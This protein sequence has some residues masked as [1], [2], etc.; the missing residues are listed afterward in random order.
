MAVLLGVPPSAC[1]LPA[2]LTLK[3]LPAQRIAEEEPRME[4]GWRGAPPFLCI[5]CIPTEK[6]SPSSNTSEEGKHH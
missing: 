6:A 3:S 1:H 2:P 4:L 5:V